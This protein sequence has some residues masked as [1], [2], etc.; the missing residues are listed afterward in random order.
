MTQE[1]GKPIVTEPTVLPSSGE[2][3]TRP[4]GS[5]K[6]GQSRYAVGVL[7]LVAVLVVTLAITW[8]YPSPPTENV[9]PAAAPAEDIASYES[10]PVT[11]LDV[12]GKLSVAILCIYGL[13]LGLRWWKDRAALSGSR[14]RD[15]DLLKIKQQAHLGSRQKLYLI[16]LGQRVVL[17]GSGESE[18]SVLVDLPADE[19][20]AEP[21]PPLSEVHLTVDDL[22][23]SV[24]AK[25]TVD[26]HGEKIRT[27][28]RQ[29]QQDWPQR[30]E[31]LIRALQ[32]K[33]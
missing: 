7:L 16:E 23:E 31:L 14:G 3:T 27:R 6:L 32:D 18:L 29:D 15:E 2:L 4:G 5:S 21:P 20:Y 8:L 22:A 33:E 24:P 9:P 11:I 30:R 25:S 17:L 12:L 19:V 10:K 13:T 26:L 28:S 1:A